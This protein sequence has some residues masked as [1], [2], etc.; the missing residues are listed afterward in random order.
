MSCFL[1][2]YEETTLEMLSKMLHFF[3]QALEWLLLIKEIPKF[4]GWE[5]AKTINTNIVE[6]II[7]SYYWT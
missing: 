5:I 7:Q 6:S 1:F 2:M 4:C 3:S